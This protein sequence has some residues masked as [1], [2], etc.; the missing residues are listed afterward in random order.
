ME[1]GILYIQGNKE[2][3]EHF[4]KR[5]AERG[6]QLLTADSASR[7]L[8]ML[9]EQEIA[10]LL[11]DYN[12]PDMRLDE[13]MVCCS[14]YPDMVFA[15][16]MDEE[17]PLLAEMLV[18]Q[19][20][21]RKLFFAPWD[22]D[23]IADEIEDALVRADLLIGQEQ[24]ERLFQSERAEFEKTLDGLTDILKKQQYS[25]Y[26]WNVI[27]QILLTQLKEMYASDLPDFEKQCGIIEDIFTTMLKMRTTG[28]TTIDGFEA[29][30]RQDM[31]KIEK[32]HPGFY[33]EKIN[34]CLPGRMRKVKVINIR[35]II[36]LLAKYGVVT[37]EECGISVTSR[38][39]DSRKALFEI[40]LK[41]RL[42]KRFPD[43]LQ[44]LVNEILD[45]LS[46]HWKLER[47][48]NALLY[49]VEFKTASSGEN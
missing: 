43:L 33:M 36:W 41:G 39:I 40:T 29:L 23:E 49:R 19:H 35:F 34:S 47:Q 8:A 27:S 31:E 16:C 22:M 15:V 37:M 48:E 18:N 4:Q 44:R 13:F 20:R 1:K 30:V 6:R 11:I 26:K 12:L 5:F 10:L 45:A 46:V 32:E 38:L 7:A 9:G 25:Y 2:L 21:I 28:T 14:P 24:Q 42:K 3:A 17:D